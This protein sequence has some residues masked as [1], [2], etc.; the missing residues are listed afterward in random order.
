MFPNSLVNWRRFDKAARTTL[1]MFF[2]VCVGGHRLDLSSGLAAT[3]GGPWSA[4]REA[5]EAGRFMRVQPRGPFVVLLLA[6]IWA[7]RG[8]DWPG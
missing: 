4:A 3:S 1:A 8:R 5:A 7:A 2:G 6:A